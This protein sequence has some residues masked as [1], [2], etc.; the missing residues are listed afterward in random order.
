MSVYICNNRKINIKQ[1]VYLKSYS[2]YFASTKANWAKNI[3]KNTR[4]IQIAEE[5]LCDEVEI[6]VPKWKNYL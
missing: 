2:S 4:G 1:H 5:F 6:R 3:I